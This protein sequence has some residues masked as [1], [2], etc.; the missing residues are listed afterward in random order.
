M[1]RDKKRLRAAATYGSLALLLGLCGFVFRQSYVYLSQPV[2]GQTIESTL[3][4]TSN[5]QATTAAQSTEPPSTAELSSATT[6]GVSVTTVATTAAATASRTTQSTQPINT[7]KPTTTSTTKATAAKQ[8]TTVQEKKLS[9][10]DIIK[11]KEE[12]MRLCNAERKKYGLPAL[13]YGGIALQ[14]ASSV[15][16]AEAAKLWGHSRP[17]GR[18]WSTVLLEHGVIS[19]NGAENL[20]KGTEDPA[21]LV[22][23][24]LASP[25]H[26]KNLLDPLV[27]TVAIGFFR[28]KDGVAYWAQLMVE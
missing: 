7:T 15:R 2:A 6:G 4:V 24:W 18:K 8:T 26:R 3:P 23:A 13:E 9:G 22:N 1:L 5:E 21:K 19:T 25:G 28:D 17:D 10:S 11:A 14:A 20:G 27:T 12:I 16:A